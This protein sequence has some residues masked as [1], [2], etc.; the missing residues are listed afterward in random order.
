MHGDPGDWSTPDSEVCQ[1]DRNGQWD[2]KKNQAVRMAVNMGKEREPWRNKPSVKPHMIGGE[3]IGTDAWP[4]ECLQNCQDER[5]LSTNAPNQHTQSHWW[6]PE[7]NTQCLGNTIKV[8]MVNTGGNW[9][10][11]EACITAL[12]RDV[13]TSKFMLLKNQTTKPG[14]RVQFLHWA[15][16]QKKNVVHETLEEDEANAFNQR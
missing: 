5:Q 14:R 13:V 11:R 15:K 8:G 2:D 16:V 1:Q 9:R 4:K 6:N 7:V 3:W 12:K 10:K